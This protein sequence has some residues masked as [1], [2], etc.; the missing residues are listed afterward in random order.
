M[1]AKELVLARH[2]AVRGDDDTH[3]VGSR[4]V[5]GNQASDGL[6]RCSRCL[7]DIGNDWGG[8]LGDRNRSR[9]LLNL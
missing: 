7:L 3:V 1:E 4:G 6:L 5:L 8:L 9:G 2:I